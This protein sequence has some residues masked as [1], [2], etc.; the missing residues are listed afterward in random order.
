V[1]VTID[2]LPETT[3]PGSRLSLAVH[4]SSEL[5]DDLEDA[6]VNI[7]ITN[8]DSTQT[9]RFT[10][11]ID[12]DAATYIGTITSVAPQ[13]GDITISAVLND[14]TFGSTATSRTTVA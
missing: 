14:G 8:S 1:I 4:V 9:H 2:P 12:A 7:T 6:I 13:A 3:P 10:G 11:T 5:K